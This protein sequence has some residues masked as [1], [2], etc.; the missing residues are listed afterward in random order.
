MPVLKKLNPDLLKD[1]IVEVR[2]QSEFPFEILLGRAFEKLPSIGYNYRQPQRTPPNQINIQFDHQFTNGLVDLTMR[3]DRVI[4]NKSKDYPLWDVYYGEIKKIF[5]ELKSDGLSY[6]RIGLRYINEFNDVNIFE[7]LN[8][9]LKI[10][11]KDYETKSTNVKTEIIDSDFRIILNVGNGYMTEPNKTI[12]L[13]D[14]DV[15]CDQGGKK[16]SHEELLSSIDNCHTK[17]K[18]IFTNLLLKEYIDTLDP[19]FA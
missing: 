14:I 1:T 11:F 4:F 6:L 15:I 13:L 10:K 3:P 19:E 5:E 16:M 17:E 18:E 12:S 7:K 2:F 9:D 8:D